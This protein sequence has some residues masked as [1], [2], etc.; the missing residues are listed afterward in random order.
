MTKSLT[1]LLITAERLVRA[2][3]RPGGRASDCRIAAQSRPAVDDLPSLVELAIRLSARKP[4]RVLLLTTEAWT[5]TVPMAAGAVGGM[6][7]EEMASALAF[8][9]EPFSGIGAFDS[10]GVCLPLPRTADEPQFWFTQLP[11]SQRDSLEYV[12]AQSGGKLIGVAHPAGLPVSLH[13]SPAGRWQRVELWPDAVVCLRREGHAPVQV[14]IINTAPRSGT[15][16]QDARLWFGQFD[17]PEVAE[18]LLA[19]DWTGPSGLDESGEESY[20]LGDEPVLTRWMQGW[21]DQAV[22][23]RAE[24][25]ILRPAPKQ[26]PNSTRLAIAGLIGVLM[27]GLCLGHYHW[28]GAA[29]RAAQDRIAEL[30]KPAEELSKA[31]A[32][33]DNLQQQLTTLTAQTDRMQASVDACLRAME[34]NRQRMSQLLGELAASD[35][36]SLVIQAI[37]TVRDGIRVR[38]ISRGPEQP[39]QLAA[40]L[41]AQLRPLGLRVASP[42]RE[43]S[44]LLA[45]GGPYMFELL[46]Q[47]VSH[48]GQPLAESPGAGSP[49][50]SGGA[51]TPRE[52]AQR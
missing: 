23:R 30:K 35:P 46:I 11:A 5:Q 9:A 33:A 7:E 31:Q 20:D 34:W 3:L 49:S 51:A 22:L 16:Q 39:N 2:D 13:D 14:H 10:L 45:D 44:F 29:T 24:A 38:G 17:P 47:D 1:I 28:T 42:N 32:E 12:V 6:S 21:A 43:A 37:E 48:L 27:L 8:E 25:P 4:R 41:A 19:T 26:M 18:T 36:D 50:S 40:R 15:W 52:T